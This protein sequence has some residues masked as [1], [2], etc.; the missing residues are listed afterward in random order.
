MLISHHWKRQTVSQRLQAAT[1]S[2][3][4]QLTMRRVRHPDRWKCGAVGA[5]PMRRLDPERIRVPGVRHK[6]AP[7][8]PVQRVPP[9]QVPHGGRL[10]RIGARL[11]AQEDGAVGEALRLRADKGARP[12]VAV[13]VDAQ[14]LG[15]DEGDPV[16][17]PQDDPARSLAEAALARE[18]EHGVQELGAAGE[19]DAEVGI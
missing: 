12:P 3:V 4:S 5:D 8:F 7:Q 6:P 18:A 16:V 17:L 1:A 15:L 13:E 2:V 9:V 10:E 19:V 14:R 11:G